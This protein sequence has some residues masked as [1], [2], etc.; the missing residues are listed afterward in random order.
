MIVTRLEE[1]A[2]AQE[3]TAEEV[4]KI[5][6]ATDRLEAGQEEAAKRERLKAQGR[7]E[8]ETQKQLETLCAKLMP[9]MEATREG[10]HAPPPCMPGTREGILTEIIN[11]AEDAGDDSLNTCWI[12]GLA[13]TGWHFE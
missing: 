12:S 8:A 4:R 7:V 6:A 5:S 13:G 11:W 9:A 1:R 3:Q 10:P 2:R